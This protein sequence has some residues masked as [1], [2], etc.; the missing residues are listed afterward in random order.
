MG[1]WRGI[2]TIDP[3]EQP[4]SPE[5]KLALGVIKQA[6]RDLF[7]PPLP[8]DKHCH[9]QDQFQALLWILDESD[10]LGSFNC[11]CGAIGKDPG[12]IRKRFCQLLLREQFGL[13]LRFDLEGQVREKGGDWRMTKNTFHRNLKEALKKRMKQP[14]VVPTDDGFKIILETRKAYVGQAATIAEALLEQHGID[15]DSMTIVV[16]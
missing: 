14:Q 7:N 16:K 5:L 9:E 4:A 6:W 8:G 10:Q 15:S 3:P 2:Q 11:W 1:R 12:Y 13:V